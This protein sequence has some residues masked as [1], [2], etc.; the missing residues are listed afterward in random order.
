[1]LY[2]QQNKGKSTSERETVFK[3]KK[4]KRQLPSIWRGVSAGVSNKGSK[5]NMQAEIN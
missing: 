4:Q 5:K 1:M 2:I 3:D